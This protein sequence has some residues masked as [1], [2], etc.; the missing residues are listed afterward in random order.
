VTRTSLFFLALLGLAGCRQTA[1]APYPE[2]VESG[3]SPR[4]APNGT[5]AAYVALSDAVVKAMPEDAAKVTF[6]DGAREAALSKL[7]PSLDKLQRACAGPCEYAYAA[8]SAFDPDPS[9]RGWRLLGRGFAWR[10][11]SS[12]E[13]GDT[14]KAVADVL[15]A[16]KFGLDLTQG[17]TPTTSLGFTVC[18]EARQALAPKLGELSAAQLARLDTGL[19]KILASYPGLATTIA[20]ERRRMLLGVQYVQDCYR[21]KKFDELTRRLGKDCKPAV[22]YLRDLSEAKRPAYFEGFA[23][24]AKDYADHWAVQADRSASDRA[25]WEPSGSERPW[26]RF[27]KALFETVEPALALHDACLART[28][29]LALSAWAGS[30]VKASGQAPLNLSKLPETLVTDP[31]SGRPFV[32]RAAGGDFSVYSVGP[33]GLDDGGQDGSSDTALE[34]GDF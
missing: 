15:A 9:A 23:S 22:A 32:Y 18:N 20:H 30:K 4:P 19:R 21:S 3:P 12:L 26:R 31:Y 24:E 16:T 28:R 25:T 17:D 5:F 27:A 8:G 14:D 1:T 6:S 34:T 33:D 13:S 29:L 2:W 11:R 10:I 7:G